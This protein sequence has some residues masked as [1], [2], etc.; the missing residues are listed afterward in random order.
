MA[1]IRRTKLLGL[2][3]ALLGTLVAF[4]PWI[5]DLFLNEVTCRAVV[6]MIGSPLFVGGMTYVFG[7]VIGVCSTLCQAPIVSP[8]QLP[9]SKFILNRAVTDG[10]AVTCLGGYEVVVLKTERLSFG[11]DD[12]SRPLFPDVRAQNVWSATTA[13]GTIRISPISQSG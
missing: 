3:V 11:A 2:G 8:A 6:P 7:W 1:G 13:I 9:V 10:V 5:A 4:R 12:N